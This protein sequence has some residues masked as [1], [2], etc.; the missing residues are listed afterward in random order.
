MRPRGIWL[1]AY[2]AT[3]LENSSGGLSR[4]IAIIASGV[5]DKKVLKHID[6]EYR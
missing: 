2:L 5:G 6:I 1:R 4:R 3:L